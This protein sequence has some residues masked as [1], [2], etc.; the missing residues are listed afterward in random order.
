MNSILRA[1]V[2]GAG[3]FGG[4]HAAKWAGL[5]GV[6]LAAVLDP[7]GE[8]AAA[9]ADRHGARAVGDVADFLAAVDIVSIAS[10]AVSHAE[11]V[12]AALRAGKPVYVEKP[13]AVALD[14]AEAIVREADRRGL[15][16]ACGFLERIA[17]RAIGLF[18]APERPVRIEAVRRGA[19]SPR[20][21]D[22]SVVLDLMIHDLDLVLTLGA[23]DPYA[24][25]AEGGAD[26]VRAEISFDD[27]LVAIIEASRIAAAPQ[28][29]MLVAYP[30]G[31]VDIDLMAGT[32]SSTAA[33][34]VRDDFATL[35]EVR[36]RLG[37]SIAAFLAAVRGEAGRPVAS[38]ADG[39]RALDLGL[40]VELALGE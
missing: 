39:A 23:G 32:V 9:L 18:D 8:R 17:L 36:D 25:E 6:E 35:P 28:R 11:W 24:V 10:P 14:D 21:R 31:E 5:A 12:L 27:G 34:P 2:I 1:G 38:A 30:S 33:F 3:V 29:R 15:I 22:V 7:D 16:V 40:A 20:N 26:E 19:P 37:A 4:Y 13:L